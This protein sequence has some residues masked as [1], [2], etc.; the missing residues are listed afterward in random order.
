MNYCIGIDSGGTH[1]RMRALSSDG[2]LLGEMEGQIAS[3]YR[4]RREE[5]ARR[6]RENLAALLDSFGGKPED[7][8]YIVCGSTGIDSPED[9]TEVTAIYSEDIGF[10]CPVKIINDAELAL[11]TV[12]GGDGVLVLSGTGSIAC[13]FDEK[14]ELVRTGGWPPG[15]FGDEGSG[16]WIDKSALNYLGRWYDGLVPQGELIH[17][18]LRITGINGRKD[19]CDM[20]MSGRIPQLGAGVDRAAA[21]GDEAAVGLLKRAAAEVAG[22]LKDIVTLSGIDRRQPD[23]RVAVWGSTILKSPVYF[24]TF[25]TLAHE[26]YPACQVMRPSLT[27]VEGA[28]EMALKLCA[29]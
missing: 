18:I 24:E 15:M 6:I 2:A 16:Q 21:A 3:H 28:A 27:A 22:L 12:T 20:A 4:F 17:E 1:Y 26:F 25:C 23:F 19:L 9:E 14:G 8:L 29:I 13:G 11:R 5:S 7:C 10:S